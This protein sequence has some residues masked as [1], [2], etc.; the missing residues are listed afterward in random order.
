[1]RVAITRHT[2]RTSSVG[3]ALV[4]SVSMI[5]MIFATGSFSTMAFCKAFTR[6][7]SSRWS[8]VWRGRARTVGAREAVCTVA[9]KVIFGRR[10]GTGDRWVGEAWKGGR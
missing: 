5:A 1:M 6:E 4:L 10:L 3:F 2:L 8:M 7:S 9:T